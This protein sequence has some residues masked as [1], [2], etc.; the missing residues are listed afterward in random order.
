LPL[1]PLYLVRAFTGALK[2]KATKYRTILLKGLPRDVL[3]YGRGRPRGQ[4]QS[5]AELT[6]LYYLITLAKKYGLD[7]HRFLTSFLDAWTHEKSSY[8]GTSIQLR[9]KTEDQC[10]FLVTQDENVIAQLHLTE[11]LLK[12]LPEVDLASFPFVELTRSGKVQASER[13]DVQ[14][15]DINAGV[16]WVNLKARVVGKSAPRNVFSRFG[17]AL[18]LSTATI[19]DGTGCMRLPLWNAQIDRISIGDRVHIE[20]G[21]VG[22]FRGELQVTIGRNGRLQV[23]ED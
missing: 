8:N 2:S 14:I 1:S 15:K 13:G 4:R 3:H 22:M 17:D 21:R 18:A 9:V 23:I 19:S 12:Y 11:K 20:N 6:R 16:K 7:A 5:T 10:V